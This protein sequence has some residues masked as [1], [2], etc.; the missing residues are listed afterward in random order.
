MVR[1]H[2]SDEGVPMVVKFGEKQGELCISMS[3]LRG[4]RRQLKASYNRFASFS[5]QQNNILL[6][7]TFQLPP[8]SP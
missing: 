3:E 4:G 1:R 8:S 2:I 5:S 6:N 7:S